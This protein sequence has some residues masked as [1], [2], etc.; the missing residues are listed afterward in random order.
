MQRIMHFML[1][2]GIFILLTGS[3]ARDSRNSGPWPE[4]TNETKPWSRW[5]WMG[6]AVDRENI[7]AL[8]KEYADAGLGGL[9]ITPIYGVQGREEQDLE[10]LSP[11]WMET[12]KTSVSEAERRGMGMDMNLGT[13]WPFG[14]PQ[15]TPEHAA[16][17]LI[18]EKFELSAGASLEQK[19]APQNPRQAKSGASLEALMA[20][21]ESGEILDLT[22]RVNEEGDLSWSPGSGRWELVAAFC[23]KTRQMVK[24]AAPGGEGFTMNVQEACE[25]A[26]IVSY[27]MYSSFGKHTKDAGRLTLRSDVPPWIRTE[28]TNMGYELRF[29]DKTSGPMNAIYFDWEHETF[30]GGSSNYGED[31]G[32]AW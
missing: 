1:M 18:L 30:W 19:V 10:Y 11:E 31:Y 5:W 7:S 32:I 25:A 15:I 17:L 3:C 24:R 6:S 14:G 9:E 2:A 26:N 16:S 21:S 29:R 20:Y 12:L 22:D 4:I 28:L 23:G 8:M 27:Q 13:G